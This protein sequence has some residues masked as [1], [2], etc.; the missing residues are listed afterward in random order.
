MLVGCAG[1]PTA[2]SGPDS[3]R[4]SLGA[5]LGA[6]AKPGSGP[7]ATVSPKDPT[8]TI[9]L[10]NAL[11]LALT[12]NPELAAFSWEVRAADARALQASLWP[13]PSLETEVEN[14]AGTGRTVGFQGAETT[15]GISQLIFTAR[16]LKKRTQ[17]ARLG[18]DLARREY[19]TVRV[20]VFTQVAQAFIGV[21]AAQEQLSTTRQ[22]Y[23]LAQKV[24]D[25][26]CKQ[27]EAGAVSPIEQTRARV[28]LSTSRI[29]LEHAERALALARHALVATWGGKAAL[30]AKVE[31]QF[32]RMTELPPYDALDQLVQQN[33]DLARWA[34]EREERRAQLALA[35]A[36]R[37]PDLTLGAGVRRL[38]EGDDTA[39]VFG[40][41]LPLPL[42]NR[43]QGRISEAHANLAK[44]EHQQ[45]FVEVSVHAALR[46]AY[47]RL[48]AAYQEAQTLHAVTLPAAESAFEG[49]HQGYLEGKFDY[50][51]VLDAQRTLFATR[52]RHLAALA[53]YHRERA[54]VERLIAQPLADV[55]GGT[56]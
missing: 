50:L 49:T 45:R 37:Y 35:Q 2:R 48:Q 4:T 23:D 33:P 44:A 47:E 25:T 21:L 14:V 3:A 13:N 16:K 24:F 26:I 31:G 52:F 46:Q 22:T 43:N 8:G 39:A 29:D 30:F 56:P 34:V 36:E 42:F 28:E 1:Q 10:R 20:D 7:P 32:E 12:N 5:E 41:S 9:T 6:A 40:F 18:A 15:V 19:E 53:N 11:E 55:E 54:E 51:N 27:V 17:V 38:S